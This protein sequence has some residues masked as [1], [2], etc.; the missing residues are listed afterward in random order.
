[1]VVAASLCHTVTLRVAIVTSHDNS[2]K[3]SSVLSMVYVDATTAS[4][5][6]KDDLKN[7]K[8]A[9]TKR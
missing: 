2:D 1:M 6:M 4:Q 8:N 9:L 7:A 3:L 5:C